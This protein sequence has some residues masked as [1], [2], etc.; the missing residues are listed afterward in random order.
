MYVPR[1]CNEYIKE[2]DEFINFTKKYMLDYV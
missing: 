1:L 2:L